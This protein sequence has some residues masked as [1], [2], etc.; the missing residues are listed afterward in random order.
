MS[1][2]SA[3]AQVKFTKQS[4]TFYASIVSQYGDLFQQ[5]TE[6]AGA[7]AVTPSYAT[8]QPILEF[9]CIS[10]RASLGEQKFESSQIQWY[11]NDTE[12]TFTNN[13][14]TGVYEGLFKKVTSNGRQALQIVKDIAEAAGYASATIKAVAT[15]FINNESD[16]IQATYSIQIGQKSGTSHKVVIAS[17][18]SNNFVITS[19]TASATNNCVLKAQTYF[20]GE[21]MEDVS[22]LTYKWYKADASATDGFTLISGATSQTYTV[23]EADIDTYAEFKVEVYANGASDPL[24]SDVQGVMDATDPYM[25]QTNPSPSTE[26]IVYGTGGTVTYTPKIVTRGGEALGKEVLFDF[27]ANDPTGLYRGSATNAKSFTVTEAMCNAGGGTGIIVVMTS[28]EF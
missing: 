1:T 14:S 26:E 13:V 10:S 19:K 15:I 18:D 7:I 28:K 24:G 8:L 4:G 23:K 9:V 17:G 11:M 6:N 5:Y 12:I 27:V 21:L 20:N 25:V 2:S 3:T 16:Q 22:G